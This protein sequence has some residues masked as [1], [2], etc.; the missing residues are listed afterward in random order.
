MWF[1]KK[2]EKLLPIL[3]LTDFYKFYK[4]KKEIIIC[5]FCYFYPYMTN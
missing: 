5:C 2:K 3:K 4:I 1:V